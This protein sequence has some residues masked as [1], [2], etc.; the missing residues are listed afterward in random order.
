MATSYVP[1]SNFST[2]KAGETSDYH[3][4][5][6]KK[7]ASFFHSKG[8]GDYSE[9]LV[10]HKI[11]G[12]LA[13]LLSDDDL[14]D[15]GIDVVGDR[16]MFR[17]YLQQ[18]SRH[19]RFHSRIK[20]LWEAEER[21][22]Y[23]DCDR[24]CATCC[25]LCPIDPSTYKL[26]TSHLRVNRVVH[27]RCGPV[28]LCCFG[29]TYTSNNIDLSKVDDVDVLGTPAPCLQR[30]C[31]CANGKDVVQVDSRFEKDGKVLLQLAQGDGEA[32]T[33]LILNQVEEAQKMDRGF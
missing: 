1:M 5:D 25:G 21:L 6:A 24:A 20:S 13:P 28:R 23:S 14:K 8:L 33:N 10:R 11:T 9:T 7:L 18:L 31:C 27:T 12:Q 15:M 3:T 32:V 29:A 22:F 26:T 19:D 16:L 4:W 30:V 17:H 2:P